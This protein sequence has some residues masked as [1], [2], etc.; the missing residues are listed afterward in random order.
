MTCMTRQYDLP[1]RRRLRLASLAA[2]V[3]VSPTLALAEAKRPSLEGEYTLDAMS[4]LAGGVRRGGG[5]LHKLLIAGEAPLGDGWTTFAS[6][7]YVSGVK[8]SRDYVGDRQVVDN[9]EAADVLTPYEAWVAYSAKGG[10]LDFRL[11]LIDLNRDFDV[12]ESGALFLN[13]SQGVGP[14]LSQTG[15]NGPS[16]FPVTGLAATIAWRQDQTWSVKLGV[17]DGAP[18]GEA[19]P[20]QASLKLSASEGALVI[21]E[22]ERRDGPATLRVGLWSYTAAYD[23]IDPNGAPRRDNWGGYALLEDEIVAARPGSG[24]LRAWARLGFGNGQINPVNA[25]VGGGLV[26]DDVWRP[27]DALGLAMAQ[28]RYSR[29]TRAT[30]DLS[31]AETTFELT[32]RFAITSHLEAQPNLQVVLDPSGDRQLPDAVVAGVRFKARFGRPET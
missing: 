15:S 32:Y 7:E 5:L 13:S 1:A 4:N 31:A 26:R 25:Y 10:Q 21:G 20:S 27:G 24:A 12:Q 14:E 16:I 29:A 28:A 8:L 2:M 3:S 22:V 30:Q 9:I 17:F 6:V 11:G 19:G 23:A 18:G